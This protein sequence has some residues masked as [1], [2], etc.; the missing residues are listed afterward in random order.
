[1]LDRI[2]SDF[3]SEGQTTMLVLGLS[4][5]VTGGLTASAPS[6]V[7]IGPVFGTVIAVCG[8]FVLVGATVWGGDEPSEDSI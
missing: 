5:T 7:G 1:M 3:R 6:D 8:L 4:M 2:K